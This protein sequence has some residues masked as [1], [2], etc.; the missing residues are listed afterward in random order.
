LT[1][2]TSS[3]ATA[4]TAAAAT[5]SALSEAIDLKQVQKPEKWWWGAPGWAVTLLGR[6]P[7]TSSLQAYKGKHIMLLP[8]QVAELWNGL[9]DSK[10]SGMECH[11]YKFLHAVAPHAVFVRETS[12]LKSGPWFYWTDR[13]TESEIMQGWMTTEF[14]WNIGEFPLDTCRLCVSDILTTQDM[15]WCGHCFGMA[16]S[17]C[18]I[19]M[20]RT[21]AVCELCRYPCT[22]PDDVIVDRPRIF[23]HYP[24]STNL[25]RLSWI[26]FLTD[27]VTFPTAAFNG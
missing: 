22:S 16:H 5:P 4:S 8:E 10:Q 9:V 21:K 6:H 24:K 27:Y 11:R 13:R 20:L 3:A 2:S 15:S 23:A 17:S 7:L 26:D 25:R 19:A 18:K 12:V 14:R 1:T